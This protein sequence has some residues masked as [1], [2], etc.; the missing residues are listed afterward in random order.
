MSNSSSYVDI[1]VRVRP[2]LVLEGVSRAR[3]PIFEIKVLYTIPCH[4]LYGQH[5]DE[6]TPSHPIIE[7]LL[8][9]SS[10]HKTQLLQDH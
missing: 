1:D 8:D 2:R 10:S 3:Q 5:W 4:E 7:D 9:S 6:T